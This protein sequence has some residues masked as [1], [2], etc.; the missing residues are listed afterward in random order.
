MAKENEE[1]RI[2]LRVREGLEKGASLPANETQFLERRIKELEGQLAGL[3]KDRKAQEEERNRLAKENE[4]YRIQLRVREGLEKGA[5][6]KSEGDN[7]RIAELEQKLRE[8][9]SG[10]KDAHAAYL[11]KRVK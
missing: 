2:Q 5:P 7:S 11:E 6:I 10:K 1:Y 8:L 3:D 9:E 4:E